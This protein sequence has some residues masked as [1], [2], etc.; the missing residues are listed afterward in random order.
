[1]DIPIVVVG[2]NRM[3]MGVVNGAV[4]GSDSSGAHRDCLAVG[5][6]VGLLAILCS[7]V[8]CSQDL[9]PDRYNLAGDDRGIYLV[10]LVWPLW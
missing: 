4:A 3:I 6:N 1:M 8:P 2:I 10:L 9:W 5:G 7:E